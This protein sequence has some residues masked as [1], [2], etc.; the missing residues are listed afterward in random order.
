MPDHIIKTRS[1]LNWAIQL[2]QLIYIINATSKVKP[3]V[4]PKHESRIFSNAV[5]NTEK[6]K[7]L[8]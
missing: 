5:L 7:Q 3:D 6:M 4:L 2:S 8:T 1:Q